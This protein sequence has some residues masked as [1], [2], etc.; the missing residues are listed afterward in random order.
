MRSLLKSKDISEDEEH[1]AH[2]E[3]ERITHVFVE[4]VDGVGSEKEQELLEV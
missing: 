2:D 4:Q 3:L 1:R